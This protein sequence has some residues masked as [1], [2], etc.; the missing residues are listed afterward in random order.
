MIYLVVSLYFVCLPINVVSVVLI[1]R[2]RVHEHGQRRDTPTS[3]GADRGEQARWLN[4][5]VGSFISNLNFVGS[6]VHPL[7]HGRIRDALTSEFR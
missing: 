5:I 4:D 1:I 3:I 2:T 7:R 6:A